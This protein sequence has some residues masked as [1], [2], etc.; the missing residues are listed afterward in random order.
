MQGSDSFSQEAR[1]LAQDILAQLD[2]P[3]VTVE[4]PF[5]MGPWVGSVE[6]IAWLKEVVV[7]QV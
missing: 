7:V 4:I 2:H 1:T 6:A 5:R 3:A